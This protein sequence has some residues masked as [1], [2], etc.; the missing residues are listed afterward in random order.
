MVHKISQH[1]TA[2]EDV[3]SFLAICELRRN[4]MVRAFRPRTDDGNPQ[5][6][7]YRFGW[8]S[9]FI[10]DRRDKKS[11]DRGHAKHSHR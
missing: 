9:S 10:F 2:R 1:A 3:A 11:R 7:C 6:K 5:R 8:G 4:A